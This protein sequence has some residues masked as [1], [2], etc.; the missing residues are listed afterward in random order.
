MMPG[1]SGSSDEVVLIT[2]SGRGIGAAT[3]RLALRK[4]AI[5]EKGKDAYIVHVDAT[6]P[7]WT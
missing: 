1:R 4:R 2:G 3:A 5:F 7:F 6:R